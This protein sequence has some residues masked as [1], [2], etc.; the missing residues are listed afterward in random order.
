MQFTSYE[1]VMC[2]TLSS[3]SFPR[4]TRYFMLTRDFMH[5]CG[6]Q[7]CEMAR[8]AVVVGAV[9]Q[10][11]RGEG[12]S[13]SENKTS[14]NHR[15]SIKVTQPQPRSRTGHTPNSDYLSMMFILYLSRLYLMC[16]FVVA[17][18]FGSL[19]YRAPQRYK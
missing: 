18:H 11:T 4:L 3:P 16:Y 10:R 14:E 7:H 6:S 5:D 9:V 15:N 19:S 13:S 8:V 2:R 1:C 12:S 17:R